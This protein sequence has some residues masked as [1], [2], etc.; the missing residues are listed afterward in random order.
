MRTKRLL[1]FVVYRGRKFTI[2]NTGYYRS[3]DRREEMLLHR[4]V[5]KSE[6]GEIPDGY[7]V[8]HID[9]DKKNNDLS[10]LECLPKAE[11]TRRYSPHCNQYKCN[12]KKHA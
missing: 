9:G 10:N 5:W 11:H 3:T 12:C 7:D 1:P 6:V 2:A 4:F 8:H